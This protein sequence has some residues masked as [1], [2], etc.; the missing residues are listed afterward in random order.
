[1]K[2]LEELPPINLWNYNKKH[3]WD[4]EQEM[5]KDVIKRRN[6][7]IIAAFKNEIDLKTQVIPDKKKFSRKEKHKKKDY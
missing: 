7:M 1:M 3:K 6:P 2:W 4:E 5:K